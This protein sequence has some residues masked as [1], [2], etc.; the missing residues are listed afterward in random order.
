M[1]TYGRVELQ[2][3]GFLP[4]A[5]DAVDRSASTNRHFTPFTVSLDGPHSRYEF[6]R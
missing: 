3:Y 4:S 1:K 6:F 2:L 5:V